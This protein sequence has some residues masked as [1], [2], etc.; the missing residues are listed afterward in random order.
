MTA[1]RR[2]HQA[3]SQNQEPRCLDTC[4]RLPAGP[5]IAP[6]GTQAIEMLAEFRPAVVSSH[7]GLPSNE[8][9]ARVRA[10]G[11][12]IIS[13]ATTVEEARWLE[14]HGVD[15]NIAQGLEAGGHRGTFLSEDPATQVGTFALLPQVIGQG[16]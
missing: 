13:S 1:P 11:S 3:T 2:P 12:K 7:F 5:M 14:A 9:P 4:R 10:F 16:R 6:V 8:V 15:A